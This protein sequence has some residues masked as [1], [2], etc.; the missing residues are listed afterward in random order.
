M[1]T[2]QPQTQ[3]YV[4][5]S[6]NGI[7]FL[8]HSSSSTTNNG[9]HLST[10]TTPTPTNS[11]ST[12][13][14]M[15]SSSSS[16]GTIS[17]STSSTTS[18]DQHLLHNNNNNNN[19]NNINNNTPIIRPLLSAA[20]SLLTKHYREID[21]LAALELFP[22]Y[23]PL[24]ALASYFN[25]LFR[26]EKHQYRQQQIMKYLLRAEHLNVRYEF[27]SATSQSYAIIDET[28]LCEKCN[29]K[30]GTSNFA[31]FPDG[32]VMHY[33]CYKATIQQGGGPGGAH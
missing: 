17:S 32:T 30:I 19:N 9:S 22:P 12:T 27:L 14:P 31:R 25:A 11:S 3:K 23:T 21:A 4:N 8:S 28:V 29:K 13:N 6:L 20:I 16:S 24:S 10:P 33:M 7:P 1:T 15:T 5:S 18:S 26:L 2:E